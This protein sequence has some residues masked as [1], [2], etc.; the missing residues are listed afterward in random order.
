MVYKSRELV[1]PMTGVLRWH[2]TSRHGRNSFAADAT[3]HAGAT[4]LRPKREGSY[5][6]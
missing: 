3:S 1:V 5:F 4:T 6:V 2:Y